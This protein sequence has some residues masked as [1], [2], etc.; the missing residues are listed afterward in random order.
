MITPTCFPARHI[1]RSG[2]LLLSH[3]VVSKDKTYFPQKK[4]KNKSSCVA[5]RQE[6]K[7]KI[8]LTFL[9]NKT[10]PETCWLAVIWEEIPHQRTSRKCLI[11]SQ[12]LYEVQF[13]LSL[14][15]KLTWRRKLVNT[16]ERLITLHHV[17]PTNKRWIWRLDFRVLE[18]NVESRPVIFCGLRT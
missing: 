10:T 16:R 5:Q 18:Q 8:C 13:S 6:R 11:K 15:P 3:F 14:Q 1:Q 7:K 4:N 12:R 2:S 17:L 9:W